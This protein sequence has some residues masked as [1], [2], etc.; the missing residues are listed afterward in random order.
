MWDRVKSLLKVKEYIYQSISYYIIIYCVMYDVL[1]MY[2]GAYFIP[3]AYT[4]PDG[5][6]SVNGSNSTGGCQPES[7]VMMPISNTNINGCDCPGSTPASGVL[8]DGVIP[9]ID[10]TQQGWA[11]GLFVV[12]RN[13]R[14]S[15]MIG[16]Q[17][18]SD[19]PFLRAVEL[20]Y[21]DCGILGTG[22]NTVNIHSSPTFPTFTAIA[23]DGTLSLSD[24]NQ[25]CTSLRTISIPVQLGQFT[26]YFIEFSLEGSS[27]HPLNWLHLAE[28][29]FSDVIPTPGPV[30]STTSGK[31]Y[32]PCINTVY[33]PLYLNVVG[34]STPTASLVITS[35]EG[36]S[37]AMTNDDSN[38]TTTFMPPTTTHSISEGSEPT[39]QPNTDTSPVSTVIHV[40]NP[41][42]ATADA[43]P[44]SVIV[45]ALVGV[46]L[47][48]ILLI[49]V[50]VG[51]TSC[52]IFYNKRHIQSL[53]VRKLQY[54]VTENP[55][56]G[57]MHEL[58]TKLSE[59]NRA[60]V[61]INSHYRPATEFILPV[62]PASDNSPP[63]IP[64]SPESDLYSEV[65]DVSEKGR[66]K[67]AP[68]DTSSGLYDAIP[69]TEGTYT[70]IP[71]IYSEAAP[72]DQEQEVK[73]EVKEDV[74]ANLDSPETGENLTVKKPNYT[75]IQ[76]QEP[77]PVPEKSS[78]LKDYLGIDVQAEDA[79]NQQTEKVEA[80]TEEYY[81]EIQDT[82]KHGKRGS[83]DNLEGESVQ[84][85]IPTIKVEPVGIYS[86]VGEVGEDFYTDM[87]G[88]RTPSRS[89]SRSRRS[90]GGSTG[91]IPLSKPL[92]EA[93]EDNP[94]YDTSGSLLQAF[95]SHGED[96]YTDP[97]ARFQGDTHQAIYEAVYSD[98]S[99]QPSIFKK[100]VEQQRSDKCKKEIEQAITEENSEDEDDEEKVKMYAPIYILN[101][102]SPQ[103]KR[104]P[105]SVTNDN[106]RGIKILGTGFFGKVVLAD[107]VGLSLKDLGLSETDDDKSISIQVAV[108][109]LKANASKITQ[110]AF[111]KEYKFMSRLDHPNVIRMLGLCNTGPTQFIMMEYMERG[112]LNNYLREFE[113]IIGEGTPKEKEIPV[114]TLIY[115][116]TQIA[117]AMKYLIARNFIHRDLAARNCLIGDDN[118]IKLADFGMSRSLYESHYYIIRGQAVLPVRWMATECFYGKFS[119]KTDVWAF[120]VTMWEIF[121]LGKERPYSDMEDLEVVDDAIEKEERTLLSQ[122][123]HCPDDVFQVTLSCWTKEPKDRATFDELYSALSKLSIKSVDDSTI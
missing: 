57:S 40:T 5:L 70:D 96:I 20:T 25:N 89:P 3:A 32:I 98:A 73:Q 22:L 77:P 97:D 24:R 74:D 12:N 2:T 15:I 45:G 66:S 117:S 122:P 63:V 27:V 108:K 109:K 54:I 99:V 53:E 58:D 47:L 84:S 85:Q 71:I 52:F 39:N 17:F 80:K 23:T 11:R 19:L 29:K 82:A 36:S 90:S 49:L 94:T 81:S 31:M 87:R 78:D 38:S 13:G 67:S 30:T 107:T 60:S 119:A 41:T 92:C 14:D 101:E 88:N 91:P 21:F 56:A 113:T 44:V 112:D 65:R 83:T 79:Q 26:N 51:L 116:C 93:M 33:H 121:M 1:F 72:V 61:A 55:T 16:F 104:E 75:L 50:G 59:E 42:T 8:I 68:A 115:M 103:P 48:L 34:T 18:N 123:D 102:A 43:L 110:E 86:E 95:I 6:Q 64:G 69:E 37:T 10:T 118:L 111:E 46:I 120:G 4:L 114:G 62:A 106:I 28:I 9:S 76:K 100:Q 105:L 7:C 35:D